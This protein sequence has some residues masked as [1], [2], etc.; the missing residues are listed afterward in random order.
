M[1]AGPTVRPVG[2]PYG[3]ETPETGNKI[4]SMGYKPYFL[5]KSMFPGCFVVW[6][7]NRIEIGLKRP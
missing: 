4:K 1:K 3:V 6:G 2:T 7:G 5:Q